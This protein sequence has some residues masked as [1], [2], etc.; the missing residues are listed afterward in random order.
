MVTCYDYWSAKILDNTN[1]DAIL[2]GDS[3][4]MVM[5]GH[6]DTITGSVDLMCAH[7]NAVAK[8][9]KQK[10]IIGDM[11]FLSHRKGLTDTMFAVQQI[12]Q[13]GAHAIKIEGAK[14]NEDLVSHIVE[15]G[16]PVMGHLGLTP[17]FINQL[18]G[19]RVQGKS[20]AAAD[21]IVSAA[22]ALEKAGCFSI[23]IECVPAKVASMVTEK[24]KIPIIGL[25]AG[26]DVCGQLLILH[27]MLGMVPMDYNPKFVKTYLNG[28]NLIK[29][30]INN[31][32]EEVKSNAYPKDEHCY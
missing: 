9:A 17:Q 32:D 4:M 12:L 14:G 5:H 8:G 19:F 2:V 25:G 24:L 3:A 31:F 15:S 29:D 28:Y 11:P 22:I 20:D 10:I 18:G 13:S 23:L 26:R 21:E 6:K 7:V 16:I 30:A 27:D 1:V